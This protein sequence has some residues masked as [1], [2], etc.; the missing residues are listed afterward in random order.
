[1]T[2]LAF[3]MFLI[4]AVALRAAEARLFLL[5]PALFLG[6]GFVALRT[7]HLRL[8]ERWEFAWAVGI[9]IVGM[10]MGAALHYWPLT[11]VRFGLV[12]LGPLYALTAL[13]VGLVEGN[14]FRRAVVEPAVM[15]ALL[16]GLALLFH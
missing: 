12:L 10:Q 1:L 3:V 14:P 4:L 15:L 7:L 13:A 6:G 2:V 11:P 9:G 8:N 5:V 16:W